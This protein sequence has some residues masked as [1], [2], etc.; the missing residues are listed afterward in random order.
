MSDKKSVNLAGQTFLQTA[1]LQMMMPGTN[2]PS[3][4]VLIMAGPSH[5]QS[6][7]YFDKMARRANKR[8]GDI[9]RAQV[10]NR[11]WKSP[12]EDRDPE[13]VR[14]DTVAGIV[15]RIV[16]W[17]PDP[18]FGQG[19]IG[20]TPDAA[21]DLFMDRSKGA[22]FVQVVDFLTGEKAFLKASATA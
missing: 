2:E 21:I 14:R 17:S 7:E 12:D 20:F 8:A 22:F 16:S 18:D 3:G 1:E 15:S 4:W 11:K 6:V 5:P 10:N 9:E 13:D 19:P